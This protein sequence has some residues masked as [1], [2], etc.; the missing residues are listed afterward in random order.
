M[1]LECVVQAAKSKFPDTLGRRRLVH[2]SMNREEE[3]PD[4]EQGSPEADSD[5]GDEG[6]ATD[7]EKVHQ[8][9]PEADSEDSNE[10]ADGEKPL[11]GSDALTA[12][13]HGETKIRIRI[14]K[15]PKHELGKFWN[16]LKVFCRRL[17]LFILSR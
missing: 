1:A 4:I 5:L 7:G 15:A 10:D 6:D 14:N 3:L 16:E 12:L 2:R 17:F 8:E 11:N 13:Q 9:M